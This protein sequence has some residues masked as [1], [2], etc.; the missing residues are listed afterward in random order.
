MK[1]FEIITVG[2]VMLDIFL[3]IRED[4]VHG[5]LN[6]DEHSLCFRYGEKIHVDH[7]TLTAGGNACNVGVGLSRLGYKTGLVAEMGDD[8]FSGKIVKSLSMETVDTSLLLR[9]RGTA[10]SFAVGISYGG[11]RTLFVE[12]VQREHNFRFENV[13]TKWMYLTSLGVEWKRAYRDVLDYIARSGSKLAFS[14]GT[15]QLEAFDAPDREEME[16][17]KEVLSKTD[18]LFVNKEEAIRIISPEYSA[19]QSVRKS[20]TSDNQKV[21]S[22][23]FSELLLKLKDMGAKIVVVTDAKNGSYSIDREGKIRS[24]NIFSATAVLE[25]TGAGDAYASG[26]LGAIIAN[27]SVSEGMQ[28]GAVNAASVIEKVGAQPGLL[29]REEIEK[30]LREHEEFQT[31]EW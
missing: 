21:R 30:K 1:S 23:E 3:A 15:H 9:T 16:V 14:P 13:D 26:F 31:K 8:E 22:T 24:I 19:G 17:L 27:F 6:K 11:E 18:T 25:K 7:C 5:L 20:D 4:S 2:N 10:S 28:W 12:H 29:K